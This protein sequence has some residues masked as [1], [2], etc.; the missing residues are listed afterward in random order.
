MIDRKPVMPD[1][2]DHEE[3]RAAVDEAVARYIMANPG[4][5]PSKLNVL[6]L[7][8]FHG[9]RSKELAAG[10]RARVRQLFGLIDDLVDDAEATLRASRSPRRWVP[11]F[12]TCFWF[13]AFAVH[14][15]CQI[16]GVWN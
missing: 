9:E 8:R 7:T 15:V 10:D 2:L 13:V 14:F 6:E 1:E 3:L 5:M 11:R 16:T 12:W 4:A